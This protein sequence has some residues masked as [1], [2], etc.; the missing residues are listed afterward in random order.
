MLMKQRDGSMKASRSRPRPDA[1][2]VL[3]IFGDPGF[4]SVPR[5]SLRRERGAQNASRKWVVY[6]GSA[7]IDE[8]PQPVADKTGHLIGHVV[9]RSDRSAASREET[10]R[11]PFPL[12]SRVPPRSKTASARSR[13]SRAES[14]KSAVPGSSTVRYR[15]GRRNCRMLFD[16][17]ITFSAAAISLRMRGIA[18][19][20]MPWRVRTHSDRTAP[21]ARKRALSVPVEESRS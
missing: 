21:A 20:S 8:M 5:G 12:R 1:Y 7:G 18:S 10:R 17:S 19:A 15:S 13:K 11:N 4:T 3:K 2:W 14:L 6:T 16:S 9:R